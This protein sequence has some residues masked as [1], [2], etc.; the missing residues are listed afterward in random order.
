MVPLT[1]ESQLMV[2]EKYSMGQL[3]TESIKCAPELNLLLTALDSVPAF[4]RFRQQ[5]TPAFLH[6]WLLKPIPLSDRDGVH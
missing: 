3:E 5:F 1:V 2:P 6:K 4:N